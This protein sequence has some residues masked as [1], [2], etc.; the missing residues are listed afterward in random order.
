M[1]FPTSETKKINKWKKNNRK[2]S[3]H[4]IKH[5]IPKKQNGQQKD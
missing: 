4:I 2:E 1:L 5:S 3:I